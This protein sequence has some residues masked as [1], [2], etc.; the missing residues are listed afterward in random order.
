MILNISVNSQIAVIQDNDGYVNLRSSAEIRPDNIL[1]KINNLEP[2]WISDY[3]DKNDSWQRIVVFKNDINGFIHRSRLKPISEFEDINLCFNTP[4]KAILENDY[5]RIEIST[6]VFNIK[7]HKIIKSNKYLMKIDGQNFWGTDG[8]LPTMEY[9][10]IKIITRNKTISLSD[11]DLHNLYQPHNF[12][13]EGYYDKE[14][15]TIYLSSLNS[16]GAGSYLVLWTISNK[17]DIKK[18]IIIPM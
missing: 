6:Q 1:G 11:K 12:A 13:L 18:S 3:S 15:D 5:C 17:T 10:S 4:E 9:K 2:V 14:N 8:E 16:D 7:E